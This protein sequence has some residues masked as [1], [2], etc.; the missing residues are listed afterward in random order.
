MA[1]PLAGYIRV[2]HVGGR[3]GERFHSPDDQAAEIQAWAKAHGHEVV[4]LPPEL[5]GKGS[6]AQRPIF[7][8]A[9]EGVKAGEYGGVV[10]AYLSRA[11][12]DLRVML[13]LWDEVEGAGRA[14]YSAREHI[15][16]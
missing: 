3:S 8:R 16:G 9:V 10:V 4:M 5:D 2:S 13:D 7:R 11:G 14:V 6:D 12:R 15:D 1:R